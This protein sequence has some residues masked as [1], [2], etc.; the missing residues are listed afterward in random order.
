MWVVQVCYLLSQVAGMHGSGTWARL[1]DSRP[2]F[3]VMCGQG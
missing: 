1:L 2:G 3:V